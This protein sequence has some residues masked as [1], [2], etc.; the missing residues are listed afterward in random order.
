MG[1]SCVNTSVSSSVESSAVAYLISKAWLRTIPRLNRVRITTHHNNHFFFTTGTCY[2]DYYFKCKNGNCIS[3]T[4][5]CDGT[6]DC[7]DNSDEYCGKY[8]EHTTY[9]SFFLFLNFYRMP[10][11][12]L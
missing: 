5:V 3:Y 1:C 6:N 10:M 8:S 9:R 7:G 4:S 2:T 11:S 12:T